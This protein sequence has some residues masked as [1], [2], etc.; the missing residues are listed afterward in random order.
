MNLYL[1]DGKRQHWTSLAERELGPRQQEGDR[2]LQ[3]TIQ[4][5]RMQRKTFCVD[6]HSVGQ[7][8]M[9]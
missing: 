1:I 5:T 8:Q 9:C 2:S 3:G 7:A 4:Q 6:Q